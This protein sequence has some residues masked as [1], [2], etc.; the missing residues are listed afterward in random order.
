MGYMVSFFFCLYAEVEVTSIFYGFGDFV[1]FCVF[2]LLCTIYSIVPPH[3]SLGTPT[4]T[5]V[6]FLLDN[7]CLLDPFLVITLC[8]L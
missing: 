5:I 8:G 2:C 6:P 7:R 4:S 1:L 3:F